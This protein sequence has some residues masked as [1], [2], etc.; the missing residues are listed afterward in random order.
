MLF[1]SESL[2]FFEIPHNV[3]TIGKGAFAG[4]VSLRNISIPEKT[5]VIDEMAFSGCSNLSNISF[6]ANIEKIGSAA[7]AMCIRLEDISIP[8]KIKRI[9]D[10][11]F[12]LCSN[13]RNVTSN[14]VLEYI[15]EGAF[16]DCY[17][18][19]NFN[20]PN[21]LKDINKSAFENCYALESLN[22][23]SSV[24]NIGNNA[25][26][27]LKSANN[28][29]SNISYPFA[30]ENQ[31]FDNYCY[32]NIVLNVPSGTSDLYKNTSGWNNFKNIHEMDATI[33]N[34]SVDVIYNDGGY[35]TYNGTI[36]DRND[37]FDVDSDKDYHIKIVPE[38][39]YAVNS[40]MLNGKNISL[41]DNGFILSGVDNNAV[42][43]CVFKIK[44]YTLL[45]IESKASSYSEFLLE[46][47]STP[48][49]RISSAKDGDLLNV[50]V[51]GEILT[52][53][54]VSGDYYKMDPIKENTTI[55]I[56]RDDDV[57]VNRVEK[58]YT[59]KYWTAG[60]QLFLE[61]DKK[62]KSIEISDFNGR[63]ILSSDVDNY[64]GIYRLDSNIN[65]VVNVIFSDGE[66]EQ[67]KIFIN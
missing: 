7:F 66:S 17:L 24:N 27:S 22:I 32:N 48:R 42:I 51:N 44:E 23:P 47:G 18:L 21:K 41:T 36:L 53:K 2:E 67:I 64:S 31:T 35:I 43:E 20:L 58:N 56:E 49:I 3:E 65:Y 60:N 1:R 37:I 26:N 13:L 4:N 40:V 11:T 61:S 14:S 19:E 10:F 46:H 8:S 5:V 15:G 30:I 28:I 55:L 25:F 63:N 38:D 45:V 57:A 9:E 16:S 6:P 62:I 34:Y 33:G 50:K 12:S 54:I 52:S 39:G 59:V 29:V